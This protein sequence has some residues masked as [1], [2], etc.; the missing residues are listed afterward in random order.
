M[1]EF[2]GTNKKYVDEKDEFFA[3]DYAESKFSQSGTLRNDFELFDDDSYIPQDL[4]SVRRI[5]YNKKEDWK[6]LKNKETALVLKGARF[7]KKEKEFLRTKE[8][9]SFIIKGYKNGWRSVSEFKRQL[10]I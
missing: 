9:V 10:K 4:I 2:D 5:A 7:T 6:I 8:G 1:V 3:E